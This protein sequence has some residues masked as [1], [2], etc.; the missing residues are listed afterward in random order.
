M[1]ASTTPASRTSRM[2]GWQ[3]WLRRLLLFAAL[4]WV[5]SGGGGWYVGA[6]FVVLATWLSLQLWT[7][8]RLSLRGVARFLPWFAVQSLAGASDV[9]RRALLPRMPLQPGLVR[10][11]LRL[12]PGVCRVSLANVV[13][14]L[15]GTLS[16]DL[17]DDELVVHTLDTGRDMHAMV[18]DLE[19]RIAALFGLALEPQAQAGGAA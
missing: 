3:A 19:P 8:Y 6:P 16:A 1:N 10:H 4:W 7:E 14:M 9:A 17:V 2:P 13:T 11:R 12:P 15:P 5:L 18:L